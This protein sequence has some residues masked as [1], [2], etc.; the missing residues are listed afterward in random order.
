M[1]NGLIGTAIRS[2]D[3]VV[4]L[5]QAYSEKITTDVAQLGK[6][7]LTTADEEK[8]ALQYNSNTSTSKE[9]QNERYA[10][11]VIAY[12]KLKEKI[13]VAYDA[14]IKQQKDE[15][16]L[17]VL[18]DKNVKA[19]NERTEQ[20]RTDAASTTA[21]I[22]SM[23]KQSEE[24]WQKLKS[25]VD[26]LINDIKNRLQ[27]LTKFINKLKVTIVD[28]QD[29]FLENYK[30][31]MKNYIK[32]NFKKVSDDEILI[33]VGSKEVIVKSS[34]LLNIIYENA[35]EQFKQGSRSDGTQSI[36]T[37]SENLQSSLQKFLV[38]EMPKDPDEPSALRNA[39]ILEAASLIA[40]AVSSSN[41]VALHQA[42]E[43]NH[44]LSRQIDV[45]EAQAK[46]YEQNI[47]QL[48]KINQLLGNDS[49]RGI[50]SDEKT[51]IQKSLDTFRKND[52]T[53]MQSVPPSQKPNRPLNALA[54][55]SKKL[56][57][58]DVTMATPKNDN[59]NKNEEISQVRMG[60]R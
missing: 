56:L 41:G 25:Q 5:I 20:Y 16:E 55:L 9:K 18:L 24:I 4:D 42:V 21:Q 45:A 59:E 28:N 40:N 11:D 10:E 26:S 8:L 52:Q 46:F 2:N 48:G 57:A 17:L 13:D 27:D 58:A 44:L 15:F 35:L 22:N 14:Y 6:Q 31:K 12:V 50:N 60:N 49:S 51:Y 1:G 47:S 53:L 38:K 23:I 36:A 37:A 34:D 32:N 33:P 7:V 30:I 43:V 19:D 29:K 3:S 54:A 39:Q